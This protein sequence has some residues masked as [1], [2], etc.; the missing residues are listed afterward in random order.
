M[1]RPHHYLPP[2]CMEGMQSMTIQHLN[3]LP[4]YLIYDPFEA[5]IFTVACLAFWSQAWLARTT[6]QQCLQHLAAYHMNGLILCDQW[7]IGD[8]GRTG[9]F[10]DSKCAN[11]AYCA[12]NGTCPLTLSCPKL[13]AVHLENL[14]GSWSPMWKTWF[15]TWCN[16]LW[17]SPIPVTVSGHSF[18]IGGTTHLLLSITCS[19]LWSK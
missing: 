8:M 16:S 11:S 3:M 1:Q 4:H 5:A 17:T 13:P 2:W 18:W 9:F 6:L 10:M 12:L 19:L 15:L 14:D 7:A